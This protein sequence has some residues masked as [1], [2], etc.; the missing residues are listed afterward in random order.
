[1]PETDE[2]RTKHS[3]SER[4]VS[5]LRAHLS[6]R[7]LLMLLAF[8][9]GVLS[10]VASQL[11]K[12]LVLEIK[13]ILTNSFDVSHLNWL[14]LLYPAIGVFLT[15]LF[16][17]YVVRDDIGH[18]VTKI[19]FAISR[20]QGHIKKHNCW[21]SVI[22]SSITIG[23]GGS[24][25][26]ESPAVLTGSAIGSSLGNAFHMDQKTLMV[27]IG[28]G[29]S[30]AIAAIFKAPFAGLLFTLEVLMLDLTMASLLPLLI[31]CVTATVLTFIFTGT[32]SIFTFHMDAPFMVN[33]VPSSILLG[34]FCGLVGLYFTWATNAFENFFQKL[35]GM[36]PKLLLG[37]SILS[38]L[39]LVFPPLY[40]EGYD[41]VGILLNGNPTELLN[42]SLFYSHQE[43][44][45]P[46]LALIML[47]KAFA[48]TATTSGGGCGGLFAP[49]LFLGCLCGFVFSTLWDQAGFITIVSTKNYALLGMAGV[50]AAVMHAPLTSIF[51]IAEL[52]G[53]YGMLV[54]LMIVTVCAYLT[55]HTFEPH[56]I[57][58]M[59]LAK[60]GQLITHHKDKAILTL[61][62]LDSVIDKYCMRIP[63]EMELGK[64]VLLIAKEKSDVF[65]VVD[66]LGNLRGII[67]LSHI[68]KVMFR[69]EL[70]HTFTAAQLMQEPPTTLNI[71]DS[72]T[73]V[74]ERFDRT[75][76][77]VLPVLDTSG[78]FVGLIY[79]AKLFSSYRQMLV[80]FS[81]E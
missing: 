63:P 13:F 37:G 62:N 27:L 57:Y 73:W 16:I 2:H 52:T 30:G 68:R 41:S 39:I 45:I 28:C 38:I 61:M 18:G 55:I 26:A 65:P 31:S 79:Q 46:M 71:N 49:S 12:W 4:I 58:A 66:G 21:S 32:Q 42:N 1:M 80:D 69:Q 34:V 22:A 78:K 47:F 9:V 6:S 53:G 76:T 14:Y 81:E 36:Y 67:Y 7:Q 19:L 23:F 8:L 48:S 25:G 43:L 75:K 51:L 24:V 15:A 59:R 70:Y 72:M 17:R 77:D 40:G 56:S 64:L 74:M 60:K 5:K 20:R 44:L 11:L 29:A 50:M 54:P 33:R 10:A 35:K 3:R